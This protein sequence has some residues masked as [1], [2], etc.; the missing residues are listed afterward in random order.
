MPRSTPRRRCRD[1]SA[2]APTSERIE[3]EWSHAARC[4][5]LHSGHMRTDST[6]SLYIGGPLGRA[7]R[8]ARRAVARPLGGRTTPASRCTSAHQ[9]PRARA[10]LLLR[11]GR[12][13]EWLTPDVQNIL[14]NFGFRNQIPRFSKADAPGTLTL[15]ADRGSSMRCKSVAQLLAD[16]DIGRTHSRPRVSDDNPFS[17]A[18]CHAAQPEAA[19]DVVRGRPANRQSAD[20]E[21]G[22]W[23]IR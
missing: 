14:G 2:S 9:R 11:T 18:E 19:S 12:T 3:R 5:N 4:A 8:R 6:F 10:G 1:R 23:T 15:H 21:I 16:L 20:C 22:K 17:R 13:V 7:A